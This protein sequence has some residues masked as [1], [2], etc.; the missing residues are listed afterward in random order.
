MVRFVPALAGI[1]GVSALLALGLAACATDGAVRDPSLK[2]LRKMHLVVHPLH[3]IDVPEDDP[4]R[5]DTSHADFAG[6]W[7]LSRKLEFQLQ[8]R[9]Q[10]LVRDAGDDEGMFF[11]PTLENACEEFLEL[12][13]KKFGP[14]F[15]AL[16]DEEGY[17]FDCDMPHIHKLLDPEVS[18]ALKQDLAQDRIA[19]TKR[20]GA[21]WEQAD[22][23]NEKGLEW[24]FWEYA[25]TQAWYLKVNLE[26]QGYTFDPATVEFQALG[27]NWSGCAATFPIAMGHAWGLTKPVERRFDLINPDGTL[28]LLRSTLVE[29]NIPVEGNIRLFIFK[30]ADDPPTTGRYIA[31]FWEG[32]RGVMDRPRVVEVD[33]PPGSVIEVT[34]YGVST[35]GVIGVR[36]R[37]HGRL[38][39]RVGYGSHFFHPATWAM[40]L[41]WKIS[42]EEFRAALLAGKVRELPRGEHP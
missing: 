34:N 42:L 39:M 33:F 7:E 4:R 27:E 32:L 35:G 3:W 28:M 13:R 2:T 10:E 41:N 36:T 25:K 22:F 5:L 19:A 1:C 29:Q 23:Q 24:K 20:R 12:A 31:Q 11:L 21:G 26:K 15:V 40:A 38:R 8:K 37:A 16:E 14:R 17:K 9:Y 18:A 6:R 30:T